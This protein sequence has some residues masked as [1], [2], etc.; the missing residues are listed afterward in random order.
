M[1]HR[2][3]KI[4]Q[5]VLAGAPRQETYEP[6]LE[7]VL[8]LGSEAYKADVFVTPDIDSWALLPCVR[9]LEALKLQTLLKAK[10]GMRH[11]LSP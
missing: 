9:E 7:E 6:R 3:Q 11:P 1:A 5:H 2:I 8:D 10:E 4:E